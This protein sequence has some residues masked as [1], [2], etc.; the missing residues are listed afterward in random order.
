MKKAIIGKK[1]GMTQLNIDNIVVPVTAILAEPNVVVQLKT[2][3]KDGYEAAQLAYG[4]IREKLVS[5]PLKGHFKKA[6]T[7]AR[8]HL[9]EF[10][11][12]T[13]PEAGS[14]LTVEQFQVGEK[15]DIA[16]TSK[17]KGYSGP[18]K[19]G[20]HRGPETHGSKSH[21][22]AGS[23]GSCSDPSRTFKGHLGAGQLGNTRVVVQNLEVVKVDVEN[24]LILV[25]GAVPGPN[26]G[27]VEITN[28]VKVA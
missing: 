21:R 20:S 19:K 25:K 12:D 17:G 14:N 1:I 22:V 6:N 15:V 27:I 11:L 13:L 28:S 23:M 18:I 9:I 8:R 3:E 10:K 26:N 2:A 4:E 5:N 7:P 24:N 16:G